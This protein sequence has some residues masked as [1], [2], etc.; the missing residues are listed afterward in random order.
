MN[1]NRPN[2][3]M[4]SNK[5]HDNQLGSNQTNM[6]NIKSRMTEDTLKH[7]GQDQIL[8]FPNSVNIQVKVGDCEA[9]KSKISWKKEPEDD[10]YAIIDLQKGETK[11]NWDFY[12]KTY[13]VGVRD[14]SD[15]EISKCSL[16]GTTHVVSPELFIRIDLKE[17][18]KM[19]WKRTYEFYKRDKP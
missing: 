8:E 18:E 1:G 4:N 11:V 3:Q 14:Y 17:G 6:N 15:F 2:N 13:Q 19:H 9:N 5:L 12:D 7:I 10:F 16:W